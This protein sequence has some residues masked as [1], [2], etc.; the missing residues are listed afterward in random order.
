M[1]GDGGGAKGLEVW[2]PEGGEQWQEE[3]EKVTTGFIHLREWG[4]PEWVKCIHTLITLERTWGFPSKGLL[5]APGADA[6]RLGEIKGFMRYARKWEV[7]VDLETEVI[8][9]RD[10]EGS[11]A[12]CWWGWWRHLQPNAWRNSEDEALMHPESLSA[13]DWEPIAKT[14]GYNG[15]LLFVGC[16]LWWGDAA[17]A[18][19]DP[20]LQ[21]DWAWAVE[22]VNWMLG[23][24]LKGVGT[25]Y[26]TKFHVERTWTS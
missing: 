16:L 20:G 24:T 21:E 7:I 9:P 23:E 5:M 18:T 17:A 4:G 6:G 11:F 22:D 2:A 1:D 10:V 12:Q 19:E 3:L 13:E 25:L 26:V 14:H 8:G 15:M